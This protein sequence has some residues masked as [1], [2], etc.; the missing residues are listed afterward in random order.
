MAF[1]AS[2]SSA[3]SDELSELSVPQLQA[4]LATS[5]GVERG[6]VHLYLAAADHPSGA[7]ADSAFHGLDSLYA[8]DPTPLHAAWLGTA[9]ALMARQSQGNGMAASAWVRRSIDHLD[10]AVA[11]DP[12]KSQIRVMRIGTFVNL[13]DFFGVDGAIKDDANFLRTAIDLDSA[14][15]ST[16][17]ALAGAAKRAGDSTQARSL[18]NRVES[19]SDASEKW[20]QRARRFLANGG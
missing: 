11:G 6:L 2:P 13:P 16:L 14:D 10:T 19:K 1:A 7:S 17:M 8:A 3:S 15:A 12:G 18:W 20:K 9:E 4:R 5:R